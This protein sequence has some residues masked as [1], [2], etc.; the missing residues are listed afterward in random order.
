MLFCVLYSKFSKFDLFIIGFVCSDEAWP[1]LCHGQAQQKSGHAGKKKRTSDTDHRP[2]DCLNKP[3][4]CTSGKAIFLETDVQLSRFENISVS[5]NS[6]PMRFLANRALLCAVPF[7]EWIVSEKFY[8]LKF[9][10]P[11]LSCTKVFVFSTL[12]WIVVTYFCEIFLYL[13]HFH[14]FWQ[15]NKMYLVRENWFFCCCQKA[16]RMFDWAQII[17]R[18]N[19]A[20]F[21]FIFMKSSPKARQMNHSL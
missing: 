11:L 15:T 7:V 12:I 5:E 19:L 9:T 6:T 14:H 16:T 10:H 2:L 8:E 18:N 3:C 21:T 13:R 17:H 4:M 20:I 1:G